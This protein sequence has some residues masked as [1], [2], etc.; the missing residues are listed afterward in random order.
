MNY[1]N[2]TYTLKHRYKLKKN[3]EVNNNNCIPKGNKKFAILL[4]LAAVFIVGI[5]TWFTLGDNSI[6][7]AITNQEL[8]EK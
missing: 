6:A 7:R 1:Y 2:I 4:I 3:D 5:A 8:A